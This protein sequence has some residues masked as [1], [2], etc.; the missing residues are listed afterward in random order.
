M[1]YKKNNYVFIRKENDEE[2][3]LYN[4]KKNETLLMNDIGYIIFEFALKY[5]NLDEIIYNV[6]KVT[7]DDIDSAKDTIKNF[8]DELIDKEIIIKVE[9][10]E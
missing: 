7:G 10:Y 5:E 4:S 6:C 3:L 1:R 2:Y 8:I 9:K